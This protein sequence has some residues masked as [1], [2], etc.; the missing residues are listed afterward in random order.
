MGE[1]VL[2]KDRQIQSVYKIRGIFSI[3]MEEDL[4]RERREKREEL[5]KLSINPY[6]HRYEPTHKAAELQQ[7]YAHL[8]PE[9]KTNDTVVV[10][11]RLI[12]IRRMG[13]ATFAHLLDA[14]GKIQLYLRED[15]LK[16]GYDVLGL[17]DIGDIIGAE[18]VMFKTKTGEATLHVQKY[19]F[20]TKALRPLPDKWHGLQDTEL[21]YRMRYVDLIVNP[22]VRDVFTTRSKI[23]STMRAIFEKHDFLE[24]ETPILQPIYGGAHAKPFT[25]HH[26]ELKQKMYLRISNELYLKRLI[27]GGFD[28]VYE[29][30]KDFRNEGIDTRHN[31]EF[32]AVETMAAYWDYRD[33]LKMVEEIIS[34][35]AKKV[36]GTTKITYQGQEIDLTPPWTQITMQEAVKKHTSIDFGK[37]KTLKDARAAVAKAKIKIP[38][39]MSKGEMLAAVYDEAVEAK[40]I[41]PTFV[42]DYPVEVS[43]L[44]KKKQ[45]DS[46]FTERFELVI[47]G[48]EYANVYSELNDPDVLRENWEQQKK[49]REVGYE[50]AQETDDDFLR[51]LEYGM[52]PTSGIGI[53]V[54]RLIML[55]TNAA[56]IRDVI[57]FPVLKEEK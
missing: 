46:D 43:P 49:L 51:A 27:V 11:G 50:E 35:T 52:P 12:S 33:S 22:H 25:T 31:P 6:A 47:G 9:E 23:I 53:G 29:F 32:L 14:T 26:N 20:L 3:S 4:I 57:L 1:F 28:R 39:T 42:M 24:V 10:A 40:L 21:R 15:D 45:T 13:K 8:K 7:K 19:A 48:R 18:G 44:A 16:K 55:L 17:T 36:C 38:A 5:R 56:S 37:I 34:E 30:S 54:D 41:K 2:G